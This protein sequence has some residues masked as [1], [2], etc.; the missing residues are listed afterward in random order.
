MNLQ[1]FLVGSRALALFGVRYPLH[2]D[3]HK[4][5]TAMTHQAE[6][7]QFLQDVTVSV[8]VY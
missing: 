5:L 3:E 8:C 4:K 1:A 7:Q 6:L 2:R